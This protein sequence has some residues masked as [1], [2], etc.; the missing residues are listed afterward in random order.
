MEMKT[1]SQK[2]EDLLGK[3]FERGVIGK[4]SLEHSIYEMTRHPLLELADELSGE[5]ELRRKEEGDAGPF[6]DRL[7][8][9]LQGKEHGIIGGL[10][11]RA[12]IRL[13]P[14]DDFDIMIDTKHWNE[15]KEFVRQ[16]G[17]EHEFSIES[18]HKYKVPATRM[19]LDVRLAESPL[20]K[21]ALQN[22]FERPYH[23]MPL[24]VVKANHL[25]AMKVKAYSERKEYPGGRQDRTDVL[26]L[27]KL[28]KADEQAV[29][30]ILKK[31]RP[32]LLPELDEI[33]KQ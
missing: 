5:A 33:L 19:E 20:D 17:L 18:T 24:R 8:K 2:T 6:I 29:R 27:L 25:V 21:E 16:E 31:H 9:F 11:V 7:A 3:L 14:T 13:R 4:P 10:G 23:G 30:A 12:H 28:G 22:V 1:R 26:D 15:M 32:D